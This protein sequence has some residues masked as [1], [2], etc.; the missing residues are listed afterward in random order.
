MPLAGYELPPLAKRFVGYIIWIH[1]I[2]RT[3]RPGDRSSFCQKAMV[4][5]ELVKAEGARARVTVIAAH[6]EHKSQ[7]RKRRDF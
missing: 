1:Q 6:R 5:E 2:P 4:E 3:Y 7:V